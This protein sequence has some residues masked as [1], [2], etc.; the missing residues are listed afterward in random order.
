LYTLHAQH[1]AGSAI[2][3]SNIATTLSPAERAHHPEEVLR[4][5]GALVPDVQWYLTQQLV[6][7]IARLCEPIEGTSAATIAQHMGL[8]PTKFNKGVG[9]SSG[10]GTYTN[11]HTV[12][13][14]A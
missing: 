4:S 13:Y 1:T 2:V 8:D 10:A 3:A 6:P 12:I 14:A 11:M 7:P 5:N 9:G